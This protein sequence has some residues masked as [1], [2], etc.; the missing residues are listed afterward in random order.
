MSSIL[1]KTLFILL[2]L[3]IIIPFSVV[4]DVY[5]NEIVLADGED[6][7]EMRV[8]PSPRCVGVWDGRERM[9]DG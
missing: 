3:T 2:I 7:L 1:K 8:S 9:S 4:Y 5:N 6:W